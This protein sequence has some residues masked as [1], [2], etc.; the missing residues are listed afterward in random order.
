MDEVNGRRPSIE[1]YQMSV[2]GRLATATNDDKQHKQQELE[3]RSDERQG[4]CFVY[5]RLYSYRVDQESSVGH[6]YE[7]QAR[8]DKCGVRHQSIPISL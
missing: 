8:F 1:V 5:L 3:D 2:V 4:T 7:K 6:E